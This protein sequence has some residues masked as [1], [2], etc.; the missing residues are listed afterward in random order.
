MIM[1][2]RRRGAASGTRSLTRQSRTPWSIVP[3]REAVRGPDRE[4]DRA[5]AG[6]GGGANVT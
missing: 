5:R 2:D 1:R 6:P 4:P 3:V